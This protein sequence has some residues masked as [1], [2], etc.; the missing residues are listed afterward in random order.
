MD[1]HFT[2]LA[3]HTTLHKVFEEE[4]EKSSEKIAV[5][6]EDVQLTYRELNE[7]AN[8][9]AHYLRSICDIQP[10]DII[11]L[12][13][14]KSELMIV[15]ILGVWKSGAAYVPIDPTYPD[16][17]IEFIVQDTKAKIVL[18]NKKYKTR[19]DRYDI[20]KIEVD[21]PLINQLINNNSITCNPDP[22]AT[23]DNLAY[24]IYTSG[25]T[26]KPKEQLTLSILSSNKLIIVSKTFPF[27]ENFYY[28]LNQNELTYLSG[29]PTQI[30]Q[31]DLRNL[32]HLRSLTLAGEPLSE[33]VFDK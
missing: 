18:T 1:R 12:F 23:R 20:V 29:T 27:D 15:S 32:K 9:L 14:D 4:V 25:T 11:A 24:V 31:M 33:M 19:F 30:S 13:L 7:K 6:Y 28:Y 22:N 5:V 16:D 10:D 3:T 21:C 2:E 26:G 17:R 8:R